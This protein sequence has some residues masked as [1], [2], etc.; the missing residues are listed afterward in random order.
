MGRALYKPVIEY[1]GG[2]EIGGGFVCGSLL[3]SQALAA[4]ST[5]AICCSLYILGDN[6]HP[7]VS[8]IHSTFLLIE[9]SLVTIIS[10][11]HA[12]VFMEVMRGW[13]FYYRKK[14]KNTTN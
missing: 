6:G 5:P 1:C 2:T 7:I 3:Q 10:V 9:V 8:A 12:S 11:S 4:F 14:F 13:K